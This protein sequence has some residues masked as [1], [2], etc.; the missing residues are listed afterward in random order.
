MRV[1][2]RNDNDKNSEQNIFTLIVVEVYLSGCLI[3]KK[4]ISVYIT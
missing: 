1:V 4:N 2:I 3:K